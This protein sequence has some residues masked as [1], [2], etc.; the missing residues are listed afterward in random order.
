MVPGDL[1]IRV[2]HVIYDKYSRYCVSSIRDSQVFVR[3]APDA[4][5]ESLFGMIRPDG[6]N[7]SWDKAWAIEGQEDVVT[8]ITLPKAAK[9]ITFDEE[10][11]FFRRVP[12]GN[13]G[14]NIPKHQCRFHRD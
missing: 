3:V 4:P 2:G 10:V 5:C 1:V 8:S 7:C 14:C 13:C 12:E 11:A 6:T 9:T